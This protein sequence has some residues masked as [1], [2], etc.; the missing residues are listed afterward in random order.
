[1]GAGNE[2]RMDDGRTPREQAEFYLWITKIAD[3]LYKETGLTFY[4]GLGSFLP[5][6]P[7]H[8]GEGANLD[9]AAERELVSRAEAL[10]IEDGSLL[11]DPRIP[12]RNNIIFRINRCGLSPQQA[13]QQTLL[14]ENSI[15]KAH[16]I[17]EDQ[18]Y[19]TGIRYVQEMDNYYFSLT[20]QHLN[21]PW[22]AINPTQISNRAAKLP[23]LIWP[24]KICVNFSQTNSVG[25]SRFISMNSV[26]CTPTDL[27]PIN[28]WL[29][30]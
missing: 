23:S 9:P 14:L 13:L 5:N 19:L 20:G 2:A 17:L 28:K 25:A 7:Y 11:V 6:L 26:F 30:I 27:L 3:E 16:R 24:S 18:G 8:K 22:F 12:F 29:I 21:P 15:E 4:W 10:G 1:M